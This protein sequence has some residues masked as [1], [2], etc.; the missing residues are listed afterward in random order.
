MDLKNKIEELVG[1]LQ[2][3]SKLLEK[4]KSDPVAALEGVI[5]ID[6]PDDQLDALV[7]GIKAKLAEKDASKLFGKIKKLF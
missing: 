1:K 4:F 3:D 7:A 6:L 2:N 5:G